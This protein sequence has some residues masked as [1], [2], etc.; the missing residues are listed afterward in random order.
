MNSNRKLISKVNVKELV[1][2]Y[3]SI[4]INISQY[5]TNI[6]SLDYIYDQEKHIQL[7]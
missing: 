5:F 3:R 2:L 6:D 7:I 4:D 1:K